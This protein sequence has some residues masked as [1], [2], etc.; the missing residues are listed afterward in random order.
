MVEGTLKRWENGRLCMC[1]YNGGSRP[2]SVNSL[3]SQKYVSIHILSSLI[4]VFIYSVSV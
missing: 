4:D 2:V 3:D 1:N